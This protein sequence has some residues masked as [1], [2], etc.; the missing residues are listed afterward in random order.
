MNPLMPIELIIAAAPNKTTG[1]A[2]RPGTPAAP[3]CD[4]CPCEW[5]CAGSSNEGA[6]PNWSLAM[7]CTM[8]GH[9]ALKGAKG[10]I[11]V[12]FRKPNQMPSRS[13]YEQLFG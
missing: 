7:A 8:F 1:D 5:V 13:V 6:P 9:F 11:P 4:D 3:P 10:H 12:K 2:G